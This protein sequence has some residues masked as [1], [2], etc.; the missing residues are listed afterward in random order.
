MLTGADCRVRRCAVLHV[1]RREKLVF[2]ALRLLAGC[3]GW[4]SHAEWIAQAAHLGVEVRIDEAESSALQRT[5]AITWTPLPEL[6]ATIGASCLQ[7]LLD[8]GLLIGDGIGDPMVAARDAAL[9]DSGWHG[10]SAI[11]HVFSR[12]SDIDVDTVRREAGPDALGDLVK[13]QGA[14]PAHFHHR[15]DAL[16]RVALD[17]PAASMLSELMARRVTCRNFDLGRALSR[18][19][20]GCIL[21]RVFGA[22]ASEE[23]TPGAVAL[24]KNHPSGGS[25]H[26]LEAYLYVQRVDDMRPGLYHYNAEAHAL[27]L[28]RETPAEALRALALV[29]VAGQGYFVDAP[30]IVVLAARFTRSFWKYRDHPKIYRAIVLEAG[31]AAQNLYLT[32]TEMGFGAFITAAINEVQIEADFGLD[33]LFEGP[34]AVCGFGLRSAQKHTVELDPLGAVWGDP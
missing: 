31:H 11:S 21:H 28:L 15:T 20:L 12:W 10:G 17:S 25:L 32:A 1:E 3:N 8:K 14:P 5:S 4:E 27:D 30:V 19:Q 22:Q 26:P 33:P 24:K 16:S 9:R 6:A 18:A 29:S 2:D 34:L 7:S 23:L 13:S